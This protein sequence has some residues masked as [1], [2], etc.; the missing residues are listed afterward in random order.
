MAKK[1]NKKE[2]VIDGNA[3]MDALQSETQLKVTFAK[4]TE[5]E[6]V[7]SCAYGYQERLLNGISKTITVFHEAPIH[8]DLKRAFDLFNGHLAVVCEEVGD[9]EVTDIENCEGKSK[10][11]NEKLQ[12][13]QVNEIKLQGNLEEGSVVM[14]GI[15]ILS[16]GDEVKLE[17]PKVKYTGKYEFINELVVAVQT[18]IEEV[19]QYHNGKCRPD[20]Q[21]DLFVEP[22]EEL[23]ND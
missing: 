2:V 20:M 18:I 7:V 22:K 11:A 10:S 13:F 15:K 8:H 5:K 4:L 16:T 21:G 1:A 19:T 14:K 6:A 12:H 23:N 9:N 3:L 17:T